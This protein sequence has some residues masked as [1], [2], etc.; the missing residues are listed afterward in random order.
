TSR[1]SRCRLCRSPEATEHAAAKILRFA[2]G[3]SPELTALEDPRPG[4]SRAGIPPP[5]RAGKMPAPLSLRRCSGFRAAAL[6]V[7]L[8]RSAGAG[9]IAADFGSAA[10]H[11]LNGLIL[12]RSGHAGFLKFA[13]LAALERFLQFVHRGSNIARSAAVSVA[14]GHCRLCFH[15]LAGT[16]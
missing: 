11:L 2:K 4:G 8:A 10:D 16:F 5:H 1:Q 6:F 13:T 9:V 14:P 7:F 3:D 12:A 15:R